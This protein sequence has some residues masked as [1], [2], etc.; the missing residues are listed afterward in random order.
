[1]K[2]NIYDDPAFFAGY[3]ALRETNG[4]LNYVLEQPA[5]LSLLPEVT[6]MRVLDLGCGAGDLCRRL[7][8]MGTSEVV[9]VDISARMLALA[10]SVEHEGITYSH[11]AIEDYTAPAAS[12]DLVVSS[13]ALHYVRDFAQVMGRVAGWLRPGGYLLFSIEHP[14]ATAAQGRHPGWMRDAAGN[15]ICWA[16]DHYQEEGERQSRWFV[17]GVVRYHR[18][19]ATV[20]NTLID[21]GLMICRVQE[22]YAVPEAEEQRPQLLEE[23]RRP[24]FLFVKARR[25][26]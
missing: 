12:F 25:E 19:I 18:T 4:G 11:Q 2:Q 23:R 14:V 22:P 5:M 20:L 1:M 8:A 10:E 17:D 13:L 9:G 15:K 16:L 3:H 26:A 24:P 7:R 6:G 21:N